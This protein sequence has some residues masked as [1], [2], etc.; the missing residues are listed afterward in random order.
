MERGFNACQTHRSIY[1][2]IF[3]RLRA[4]AR[5]WSE[6]A[7]F[8]YP[9]VFNA[10]IGVFSLEFREKVWTNHGATRQWRQFDDRLSRFDTIPACDRQ[11]D[12]QTDGRTDVQPIAITCAVWLTYVN[13]NESQKLN[14]ETVGLIPSAGDICKP[15]WEPFFDS[16][17]NSQRQS[18]LENSMLHK[19]M[20]HSIRELYEIKSM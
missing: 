13:N 2:S 5:Y 1:P 9:L 19:I 6:I 12:R 17:E 18:S 3:N 8:S 4:I 20:L 7:T 14:L 11:R 16:A 15:S 10:P